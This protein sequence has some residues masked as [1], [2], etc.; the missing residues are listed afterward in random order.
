MKSHSLPGAILIC[1]IYLVLTKNPGVDS[2]FFLQGIFLNQESKWCLLY[3]RRILYQLS[4]QESLPSSYLHPAGYL[5]HCS[6][7]KSRVTPLYTW[8]EI[9][10]AGGG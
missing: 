3:C 9:E 8:V 1:L 2:L 7:H 10:H 6:L 4:S 5:M